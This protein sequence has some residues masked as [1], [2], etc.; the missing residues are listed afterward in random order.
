MEIQKYLE[1]VCDRY[2]IRR[3][4]ELNKKVE[5]MVWND[6]TNMW[7]VKLTGGEVGDYVQ[8]MYNTLT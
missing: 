2:D 1:D 7:E 8:C 5:E 4:I 3:H 6:R